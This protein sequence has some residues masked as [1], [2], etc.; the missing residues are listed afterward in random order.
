MPLP[1]CPPGGVLVQTAFSAIISGTE[2]ARVE[3]SQKSLL[4]KARAR[5]D[6]VREVFNRA[7]RDGM[8]ATTL[9][10][11]QNLNEEIPVGRQLGWHRGRGW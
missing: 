9:A 8:R 1:R 11:Q 4:G 2:R 5:P 10:V 3:L 6:L 7:R